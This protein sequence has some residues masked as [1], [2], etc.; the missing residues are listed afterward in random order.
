MMYVDT[1]DD[2]GERFLSVELRGL[3]GHEQEEHHFLCKMRTVSEDFLAG[4][5]CALSQGEME[6]LGLRREGN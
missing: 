2:E 4:Q 1:R 6:R 5:E 3:S